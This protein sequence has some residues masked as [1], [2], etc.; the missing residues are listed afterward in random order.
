[1]FWIEFPNKRKATNILLCDNP[2][3]GLNPSFMAPKMENGIPFQMASWVWPAHFTR[4]RLKMCQEVSRWLGKA[5]KKHF[6]SFPANH[7]QA[8][9]SGASQEAFSAFRPQ[10]FERVLQNIRKRFGVF[11]KS[12]K[13]LFLLCRERF[14]LHRCMKKSAD[15]GWLPLLCPEPEKDVYLFLKGFSQEYSK[16][17]LKKELFGHFW[18]AGHS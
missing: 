6:R 18:R 10:W 2:P 3:L 4:L 17:N 9:Q 7:K 16:R 14:V 11:P 5:F 1:M 15:G 8:F 13:T 12:E